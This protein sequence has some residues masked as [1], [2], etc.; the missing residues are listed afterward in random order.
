[1]YKNK[2][3]ILVPLSDSD[4]GAFYSIYNQPDFWKAGINMVFQCQ[5]TPEMFTNRIMSL[6]SR[7]FTIRP[8]GD[9]GLIIGDAALHHWNRETNEIEIG[10]SLFSEYRG[11]GYMKCAFELLLDMAK[12]EMGIK[13][14]IGKTT[15][16]NT[17]AIRLA[18]KI[19]FKKDTDDM[20][21]IVLKRHL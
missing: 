12:N 3:V 4:S 16:D 2:K 7:I 1:M 20:D 6:C 18:E 14:V 8:A 10:G 13:K 19:G 5:E 11:K 9:Y 17:A 15:P 21:G